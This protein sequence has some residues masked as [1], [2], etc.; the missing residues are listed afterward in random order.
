[1]GSAIHR[2]KRNTEKAD[3]ST[4]QET[5]HFNLA[6]TWADNPSVPAAFLH[7]NPGHSEKKTTHY[8]AHRASAEIGQVLMLMGV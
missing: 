5:G 6:L 8:I 2:S 1:M 4:L 7:V 3:I